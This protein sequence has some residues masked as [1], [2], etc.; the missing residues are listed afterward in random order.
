M[1]FK[2]RSPLVAPLLG[3]VLKCGLDNGLLIRNRMSE[4]LALVLREDTLPGK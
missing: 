1:K 2:P 4:F 3:R